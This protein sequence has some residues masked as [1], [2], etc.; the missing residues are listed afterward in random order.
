MAE[1]EKNPPTTGDKS[2]LKANEVISEANRKTRLRPRKDTTSQYHRPPKQTNENSTPKTSNHP[3]ISDI[4]PPPPLSPTITN[5]LPSYSHATSPR[6]DPIPSIMVPSR[7]LNSST[8]STDTITHRNTLVISSSLPTIPRISQQPSCNSFNSN[9]ANRRS[10]LGSLDTPPMSKEEAHQKV[11]MV[12]KMMENI[13]QMINKK[14]SPEAIT[15]AL[16]DLTT[17]NQQ[18]ITDI[19]AARLTSFDTIIVELTSQ[20]NLLRVQVTESGTRRSHQRSSSLTPS[21]N[22]GKDRHAS[23]LRHVIA[24]NIAYSSTSG[25]TPSTEENPWQEETGVYGI[26]TNDVFT[27]QP[28]ES[29]PLNEKINKMAEDIENLILQSQQ[30]TESLNQFREIGKQTESIKAQTD[31]TT[32]RITSMD[33]RITALEETPC[34]DHKTQEMQISNL[35]E[36]MTKLETTATECQISELQRQIASLS[37]SNRMINSSSGDTN[38]TSQVTEIVNS[39]APGIIKEI[40]SLSPEKHPVNLGR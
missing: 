5:N 30:H 4:P 10:E 22:T 35:F 16:S 33:T 20:L 1:K 7:S 13:R 8:S 17:A 37:K 9:G 3:S 32:T 34:R 12:R 14:N 21:T 31:D 24:R 6:S 36:R 29:L 18:I 15:N 40:M 2:N 11:S 25:Q 39:I 19:S 27:I 28:H 38:I 23:E 26:G